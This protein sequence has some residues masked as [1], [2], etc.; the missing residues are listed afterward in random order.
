MIWN[1][2]M[3]SNSCSCRICLMS[4]EII[5]CTIMLIWLWFRL[6]FPY[7]SLVLN[8]FSYAC[9]L[10]VY[11]FWEISIQILRPC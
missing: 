9:G 5:V 8:I 3:A 10:A 2:L 1:S 7:W 4:A 6:L 11:I